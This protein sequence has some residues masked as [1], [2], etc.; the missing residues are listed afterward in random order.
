MTS[1]AMPP[2]FSAQLQ[3]VRGLRPLRSLA[4]FSSSFQMRCHSSCSEGMMLSSSPEWLLAS[5]LF[6][7]V[8]GAL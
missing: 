7:F 4:S 6:A 2:A 3:L 1:S 5:P 8:N